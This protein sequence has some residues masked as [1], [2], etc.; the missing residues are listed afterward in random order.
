MKYGFTVQSIKRIYSIKSF[1]LQPLKAALSNLVA[2][3]HM[4]RQAQFLF[5][6]KVIFLNPDSKFTFHLLLKDKNVDKDPFLCIN[7]HFQHFLK[8]VATINPLLPHLW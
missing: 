2:N 3:R 1:S 7:G 6:Y 8:N 5:L 4:W